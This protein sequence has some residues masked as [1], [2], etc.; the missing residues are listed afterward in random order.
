[1]TKKEYRKPA[2]YMEY[3]ELSQHIAVS[4]AGV[5]HEVNNLG[6]HTKSEPNT[7][8]WISFS[9]DILFNSV[10]GDCVRDNPTFVCYNN[11][12]DSMAVFVA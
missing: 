5:S 3:F 12:D 6:R 4:C 1:M 11:P 10:N 2:V 8:T 7:C 9:G